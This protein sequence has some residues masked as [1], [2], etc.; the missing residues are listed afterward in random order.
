MDSLENYEEAAAKKVLKIEF[1]E[2]SSGL[3]TARP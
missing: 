2:P 3:P 1:R